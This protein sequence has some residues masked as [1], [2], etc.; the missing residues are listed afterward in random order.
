MKKQL[1]MFL[2]L[3]G[4][5]ML[6]L[7][8]NPD[9]D[10]VISETE[11]PTPDPDLDPV[12][13]NKLRITIGSV[14][15]TGTL[16]DNATATAFKALLP[17]TVSMREMNGNEKYYYLPD[18]LPTAASNPG[19]IQVGD[20]MLYGSDCVVL[21]YETFQTSYSYTRLGSLDNPSELAASLGS[22]SVNVTFELI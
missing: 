2:L 14:S 21:F 13:G 1:F 12:P 22:G 10:P 6:M 19:T 8:C 16:A 17:M 3:S 18:N 7:G 20:L 15:F 4:L 5:T 11:T 9:V